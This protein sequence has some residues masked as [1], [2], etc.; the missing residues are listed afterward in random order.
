MLFC[1]L[2]ALATVILDQLSKWLVLEYLKPVGSFPLWQDVFH[3]TYVENRGAAFGMLADQRW[4]FMTV[5]LIT[6]VVIFAYIAIYKPQNMWMKAALAMI[7]GGGVGNMIDR[8]FR[9]Y[10]VDFIDVTCIDFYVFNIADSFVCVGCGIMILI[11]IMEAIA[12]A[13]NKKL[14]GSKDTEKSDE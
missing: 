7:A 11:V 1:V 14:T 12:E 10:V 9:G 8:V 4:V 2:F 5:S 13:K 6:I 3:L